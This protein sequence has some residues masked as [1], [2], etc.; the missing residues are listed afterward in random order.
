MVRAIGY[1]TK[2]CR[3]LHCHSDVV[4]STHKGMRHRLEKFQRDCEILQVDNSNLKEKLKTQTLQF[5]LEERKIDV[6]Q[7]KEYGT[8]SL[9]VKSLLKFIVNTSHSRVFTFQPLP[10]IK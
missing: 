9:K 1:S 7:V 8:S 2:S 10:A 6:L 3:R 4:S 5:Q